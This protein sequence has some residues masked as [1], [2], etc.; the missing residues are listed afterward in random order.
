MTSQAPVVTPSVSTPALLLE[1]ADSAEDV[2]TQLVVHPLVLLHVLDHHTRRN[3]AGGRVIGTLLGRR[4][5]NKVGFTTS[6]M[7]TYW[8]RGEFEYDFFR[9]LVKVL[10]RDRHGRPCWKNLCKLEPARQGTSISVHSDPSVLLCCPS[11]NR[12]PS[13]Q[14]Q[15]IKT[16]TMTTSTLG[17]SYQLLCCSS[18]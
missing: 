16:T 17:G 14:Q 9:L 15:C 1:G 4:D 12:F 11:R 8:Y 13:K 6:Y 3:E 10:A 2:V 7:Y 5:G 18:R